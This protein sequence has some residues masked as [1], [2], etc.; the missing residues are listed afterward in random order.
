M[1]ALEESGRF[2]GNIQFLGNVY[3][4]A[5]CISD[6]NVADNAAISA[7]KLQHQHRAVYTQASGETAAAETRV[8][9]VVKGTSGTLKTFK[10]GCVTACQGDAT[11][12]VDLLV[13]GTSVLTD[14]ITLDSSQ[15]NYQL[16][17]GT[18]QTPAVDADDVVEVAISVNAGTGTLG[19]GVFAYVDLYEDAV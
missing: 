18:I 6:E 4:P 19:Q 12:T 16:I 14:T 17:E 9:H 10:A 5:G 2:T 1:F 15:S 13:N 7:N 3:L 8:V 11:I